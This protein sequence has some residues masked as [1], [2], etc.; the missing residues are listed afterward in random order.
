MLLIRNSKNVHRLVLSFCESH[1]I[2]TIKIHLCF[3]NFFKGLL[4]INDCIVHKIN[5]DLFPDLYNKQLE[6]P[7]SKAEIL[8]ESKWVNKS[9]INLKSDFQKQIKGL[10]KTTLGSSY[11]L[12]PEYMKAFNLTNETF[13]LLKEIFEQRNHLYFYTGDDIALPSDYYEKFTILCDLA[14]KNLP[15]LIN[16]LSTELINKSHKKFKS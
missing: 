8:S 14:E 11:L 9:N 13:D 4:L 16:E 3:E 12:K 15:R 10:G 6:I 7:I 2:D 5:K 1:L